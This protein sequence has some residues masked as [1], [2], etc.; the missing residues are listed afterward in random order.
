MTC[1]TNQLIDTNQPIDA[2]QLIENLDSSTDQLR[3]VTSQLA[4][5]HDY[6]EPVR[7]WPESKIAQELLYRLK[8]VRDYLPQL[9]RSKTMILK[10]LQGPTLEAADYQKL[11]DDLNRVVESTEEYAKVLREICSNPR[12]VLRHA[13]RQKVNLM[14]QNE[15]LWVLSVQNLH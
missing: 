8:T 4:R 1:D 3:V 7:S 13:D 6:Y 2:K 14:S 12:I 5:L 15:W 9:E 11:L 10:R